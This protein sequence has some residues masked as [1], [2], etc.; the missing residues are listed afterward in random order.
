MK[1]SIRR[2]VRP[3][4]VAAG[5]V[6]LATWAPI[7]L[8][9]GP[10]RALAATTPACGPRSATTLAQDAEARVFSLPSGVY[11]CVAGSPARYRLDRASQSPLPP[12]VAIVRL[13][14]TVA[15]YGLRVMGVDTGSTTIY[16]R[17]L[18]TGA[19]VAHA[20]AT[21]TS[22][23]EA[24]QAVGSLAVRPDGAVA[25]I[26]SAQSIIR[27]GL[28]RQVERI[29]GPRFAVLDSGAGISPQSLKLVGSTLTWRHGSA[30]RSSTLR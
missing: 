28:V 24:V 1:P 8:G 23:V 22:P 18:S 4:H 26:G 30:T 6:A 9:A 21:T 27:H 16:V 2:S 29:D 25:W 19:L 13:A 10:T 20:P 17:R 15:A 12:R 11:G 14:G 7:A 5:A 3:G